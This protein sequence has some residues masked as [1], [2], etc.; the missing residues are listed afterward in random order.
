MGEVF[1][2][3]AVKPLLQDQF[4]THTSLFIDLLELQTAAPGSVVV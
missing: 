3:A 1:I 4:N 2:V